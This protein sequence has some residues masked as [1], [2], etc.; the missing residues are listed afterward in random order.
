MV[1]TEPVVPRRWSRRK[2]LRAGAGT[3]TT[4]LLTGCSW[5]HRDPPPPAPD[6]L[7]PLLWS[8]HELVRRYESVIA[9][10]PDLAERLGPLHAAHVAHLAAL[11]EVVGRDP[12]TPP[13]ATASHQPVDGEPEPAVAALR[14]ARRR[15]EAEAEQ[16]CL[17]ASPSRAVLLGTITA[18]RASHVS[19]L[20]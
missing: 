4:A 17:A 14:E 1:F 6:P 11:R 15:A 10:H 16:A 19:V 12:A 13:T 3:L 7:D 20:S 5:V 18:A 8:T 9:A 2:L